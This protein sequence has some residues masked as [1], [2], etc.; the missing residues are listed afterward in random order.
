MG[1][2]TLTLTCCEC[3]CVIEE[4]AG[5]QEAGCPEAICYADMILVLSQ[6]AP[7]PYGRRGVRRAG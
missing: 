1:K 3:G 5:C 7:A 2:G 6:S 4:C